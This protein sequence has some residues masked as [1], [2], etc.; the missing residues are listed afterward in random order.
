MATIKDIAAAAGVSSATVSRVLNADTT[1]SVGEDTR[2]R[3][4]AAAETLNYSKPQPKNTHL[5]GTIAVLQWYTAEA[6]MNDLYYRTIRWGAET[7]LQAQGYR[8]ARSFADTD[9]P[10]AADLQGIIAIGKFSDKQLRKLSRLKRPLVVVDQDTLHLGINCITTDFDHAVASIIQRFIASGHQR[11][12]MLAGQ[13]T[14]SDGQ[15]LSDPRL[16]AFKEYMYAYHRYDARFV[17]TGPFSIESG[18]TRMQAAIKELGDEL[19]TAFFAANDTIAMGAVRALTEAGKKV[20]QDVSVIGFN[21]LAIGRYLTPSM[22]TV[23]VA[24]EQMGASA[25]DLLLQQR[26]RTQQTPVNMTIA[27]ELVLRE[28][29]NW[30]L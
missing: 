14:T 1:L 10:D 15:Q 9:L 16:R 3:I 23:H 8:I 21:D 29:S 13:E 27:S 18:F 20:P 12:G 25:V 19:P 26:G 11:I 30:Q 28:S 2:Q 6:E 7:A 22:S 5:V 17:S 4:Y 24:T